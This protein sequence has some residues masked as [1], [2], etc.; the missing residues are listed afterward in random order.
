MR[1]A[2]RP[3]TIFRP[4][5]TGSPAAVLPLAQRPAV[6]AALAR[7]AAGAALA[8]LLAGCGSLQA[9]RDTVSP[10]TPAAAASAPGAQA[11]APLPPVDP[12]V[13]QAFDR[14]GQALRAGHVEEAERGYRAIVH[15][16][17]ELAGPHAAVGVIHRRAN[18]VNEAVAEFEQAVKLSP[19]QPV[20]WN[21]LGA[22]Y[23]LQ[24]QFV[25]ARDAYEHAIALDPAYAAPVLNLGILH[26]L[27]LGDGKHALELYDRYLALSPQGDATVSKWVADLKNRKPQPITVSRKEKE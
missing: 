2:D 1:S 7:T 5:P 25:K 8:G 12:A 23:R 11:A 9:I 15:V 13:Q 19:A 16:H 27:Y 20:Y 22:A 21:Q 26:D 6:Q 10:P 24:G 3:S 18:R 14:A 17:P 4:N